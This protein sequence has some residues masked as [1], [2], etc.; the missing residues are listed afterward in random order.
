MRYQVDAELCWFAVIIFL[1]Y[2]QTLLN[3]HIYELQCEM[4]SSPITNSCLR[5]WHRGTIIRG[6]MITLC[7][8]LPFLSQSLDNRFSRCDRPSPISVAWSLLSAFR[9]PTVSKAL[10]CWWWFANQI[11]IMRLRN[12]LF[13]SAAQ[14][15]PKIK[16]KVKF[17]GK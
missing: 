8:Q 1:L 7:W 11:F 14:L 15:M 17:F 13:C 2:I 6:I 9:I 4:K 12:L 3:A 10:H 16:S 5:A